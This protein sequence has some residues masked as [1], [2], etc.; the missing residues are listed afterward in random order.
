MNKQ[1]IADAWYLKPTCV[2][3]PLCIKYSGIHG[4]DWKWVC[5][6]WI[7]G[8][9]EGRRPFINSQ[10]RWGLVGTGRRPSAPQLESSHRLYTST[11][12]YVHISICPHIHISTYPHIQTSIPP[13]IQRSRLPDIQKSNEKPAKSINTHEIVKRK[14]PKQ[15]SIIG[16]LTNTRLRSPSPL[17]S[18]YSHLYYLY[19]IYVNLDAVSDPLLGTSV[20]RGWGSRD[21]FLWHDDQN[22]PLT[23]EIDDWMVRKYLISFFK[24][25]V[26][27]F[28][29]ILKSDILNFQSLSISPT[30]FWHCSSRIEEP[31]F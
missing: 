29:C 28:S 9:F 14:W 17:T 1:Q 4:G 27:D 5:I 2:G 23:L 7:H 12:P 25:C 31:R 22:W 21:G 8:E 6:H 10:V 3:S 16:Q 19:P 13:N 18:F 11:Y 15:A 26:H 24:I 30:P 20:T